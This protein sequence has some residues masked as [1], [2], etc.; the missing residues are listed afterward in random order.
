V[1]LT[2]ADYASAVQRMLAALRPNRQ[3]LGVA[4][5]GQV[6]DP[7]ISDLDLLIVVAD[8]AVGRVGRLVDE[9]IRRTPHGSYLYHHM[10]IIAPRSLMGA[11]NV[12]HLLH[13]R[14][15][16]Y[17]R[18]GFRFGPAL[19]DRV[20]LVHAV[21]WT[22]HVRTVLRDLL[23]GR[24][25]DARFVLL[26]VK[27]V[28]TSA[29]N[30][31]RLLGRFE[32][33]QVVERSASRAREVFRQIDD[34]AGKADW[35]AHLCREAQDELFDVEW[36]LQAHLERTEPALPGIRERGATPIADDSVVCGPERHAADAP[37]FYACFC[38]LINNN[39][40]P[41]A[42]LSDT[43]REQ[44]L[45]FQ[46]AASAARTQPG[47]SA[48][49]EAYDQVFANPPFATAVTRSER[50]WIKLVSG[51]IGRRRRATVRMSGS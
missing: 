49:L 35:L 41:P 6:K 1:S 2:A 45:R 18:D 32:Q 24:S 39:E 30:Y 27:C 42:E 17:E 3:V 5:F 43:L 13:N 10:P 12:L 14:R 50:Q 15:I 40:A 19:G 37:A 31:Y 34:W 29:A 44:V 38:R 47:E 11:V 22:S 8:G 21:V 20:D 46:S 36:A 9:T 16:L 4:Q 28:L 51:L 23:V 33:A 7:G 26:S 48:R 25:A